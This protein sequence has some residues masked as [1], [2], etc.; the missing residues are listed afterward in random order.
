MPDATTNAVDATIAA[1]MFS[2]ASNR[3]P[4]SLRPILRTTW[5]DP[6]HQAATNGKIRYFGWNPTCLPLSDSSTVPRTITNVP[7]RIA[8]VTRSPSST[9]ARPVANS[10]ARLPI[11]EATGAP[12]LSMDATRKKRPAAV[13][14]TPEK[15]KYGSARQSNV[16]GE[17]VSRTA[18]QRPT[19]PVI[20]LIQKPA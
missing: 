18:D 1:V 11:A 5:T 12:T 2:A 7:A 8:N 20:T 19:T 3:G 16:S 6:K 13:P 15:M 9:M 14:A 17:V 4:V 10:G